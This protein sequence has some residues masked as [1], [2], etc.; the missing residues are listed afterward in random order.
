ME[1]VPERAVVAG[2]VGDL[3]VADRRG[4]SVERLGR[5]ARHLGDQLICP[6]GVGGRLAVDLESNVALGAAE[7]LLERARVPVALFVVVLEVDRDDGAGVGGRVPRTESL[8]V[9]A[10]ARRLASQPEL[11]RP[12]DGRLAGLVRPTHDGQA[13]GE[14]DIEVAISA[15]VTQLEAG[16]PHRVTS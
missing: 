7:G 16:D 6:A 2:Q 4:R 12:L 11:D 10:G 15:E 5:D 8:E 9:G 3:V 13:R 14:G 1:P